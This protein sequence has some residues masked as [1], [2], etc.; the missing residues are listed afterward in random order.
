MDIFNKETK[1]QKEAQLINR[2][3][4]IT[5]DIADYDLKLNT[6]IVLEN[7]YSKMVQEGQLSPG[8]L[9]STILN[10]DALNEAPVTTA[11]VG[12]NLIPKVMFP[13]IRR[14]MPELIANKIVSVQ[15]LT[16]PTGVIY[17]ILYQYSNTKGSITANDEFSGNANQTS[18]GYAV[19]YSSEK[20]GPF[21]QTIAASGSDTACAAGTAITSFLGT[22]ASGFSLKRIEV[23]PAAGGTAYAASMQAMGSGAPSWTGNYNVY[24]DYAAGTI[25]LRDVAD[26]AMVP[27][28]AAADV[29]VYVVYNQEGSNLIPE[30]EF[31]IASETVS[32]TERKIKIRWTKESEQDMQAYHKIDVES[33]LVKIASLQ[34]NY[35]VDREILTFIND[36]VI[37]ALSASHD[38]EADAASSGNNTSGN[39]LDRHR[40]LAQKMH[41][42]SA[43][44][45][46]YNRISPCTWAVC[47]PQV[48][49]VLQML[50]DFKG[51]ISSGGNTIYDAG[52]LG[53]KLEIY[54]D[55][56]KSGA[57]ADEILMGFK[58]ENSTYG[59]G[60]V[61]APYTSW[62]SNTVTNVENF[63]SVRGFFN[64]Y[65]LTKV[66]RGQ[67]N[68]A[69]LTVN[70]LML[71]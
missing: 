51:E 59:A 9:E 13:V 52:M 36:Q 62:M 6:S 33:E 45:A 54:V 18:P 29:I 49:S 42:L 43:K 35:E 44:V 27:W 8:W 19:F 17:Y 37:T 56:N 40:A 46:Q 23:Y 30:M 3:N 15:P 48:A 34:M 25:Y 60:V 65:A 32:T 70:N 58:S 57:S 55:P 1:L 7:S 53:G 14:V 68:Y 61:Y 11:A 16:Q 50:P 41:Q 38:W 39:F 69:R 71:S 2:W 22:S 66:V 10:E 21:S 20:I 67:Y 64:R 4:W 24:Y 31:S 5:D 47:S 63:D 12:T 26:G 28:A